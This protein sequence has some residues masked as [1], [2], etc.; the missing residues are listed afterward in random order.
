MKDDWV[1]DISWKTYQQEKEGRKAEETI[2][3]VF[4]VQ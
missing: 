1:K 4:C 2:K 3:K